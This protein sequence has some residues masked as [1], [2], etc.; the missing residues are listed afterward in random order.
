MTVEAIYNH[1]VFQ[2]IGP[3]CLPEGARVQLRLTQAEAN[4]TAVKQTATETN[5]AIDYDAWL[6]GLAGRWQGDFASG[7]AVGFE[8][9]E[10][11]S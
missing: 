6:D 4:P 10:S 11:L 9:Y 3:V 7:D 2:P 1:G 8:T 5:G